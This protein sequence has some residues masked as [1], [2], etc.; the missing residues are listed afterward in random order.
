MMKSKLI[1][2]GILILVVVGTIFI[3]GY[4]QTPSG[5]TRTS[6]QPPTPTLQEPS[7]TRTLQQPPTQIDL[8]L[9]PFPTQTVEIS[10]KVPKATPDHADIVFTAA[11]FNNQ[12]WAR[13]TLQRDGDRATGTVQLPTN[14]FLCYTYRLKLSDEE[15][16]RWESIGPDS[17]DPFRVVK[18]HPNLTKIEDTVSGWKRLIRYDGPVNLLQG[19]V[20][21][22]DGE[23]IFYALV[24]AGG[25]KTYTG[26]DGTYSL[27]L[28]PGKHVVT[29][30][31]ELHDFKAL[32]RQVDLSA[33]KILDV[34]LEKAQKVTVTFTAETAEDL[35]EKIRI[36][37]NTYQL[38]TFMSQ[39]P[40]VY[41][42]R[43]LVVDR[44][45]GNKYT[46]TVELHDGQYL[47]YIYTCAGLY[48]GAEPVHDGSG[49]RVRRLLVTLETTQINDHLQGFRHNPKLTINLR[50]PPETHPKENILFGTI[51]MF[52]VGENQYQ[53]KLFVEPGHKFEYNYAHGI[54]GEGCEVIDPTPQERRHFTMGD[55]DQVINDVVEKWPFSD[56][57][58]RT[59]TINTDI[60]VAPRSEFAVGHN[61]LDWWASNFLTNFDGLTDDLVKEKHDYVGISMMTDYL[62]VEPEP[63]FQFWF[64]PMEDLKEA[65]RIAHT[66]GLKVIV[67][68]V[69][70]CD[71]EYQ[72]FFDEH[73][74]T[75]ISAD[76]YNA[77]FDQ[78]EHFFI[79]FAKVAEEA[80]IEVIQFPSPPP[81]VTDEY[82]D[83]IDQRMNQLITKT[84][85]VYS[86]KLYS[87]VHWETRM[88]Y[89]SN[90][91][92][93]DPGFSQVNLG[94]SSNA[95]VEEMKA[96]FDDLFD[97]HVKR[98]YDHYRV[99]IAMWFTYSTIEGAASGKGVTEPYLVVKKSQDYRIDL[100]EHERLA[101]AFMQ[102]VAE[103][104]YI[105]L[106]LGRDYSY[107]HLPS[108]PGPGF[109]SKPAA[110]V[111][112]EY[113]ELI[114]QAIQQQS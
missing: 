21:D 3:S 106:V 6:Q 74:N 14:T 5:P 54:P 109:R 19:T 31:T 47:E 12:P 105:E 111:W 30:F 87:P 56:Y 91:D 39:G 4:V 57:G 36:V 114:K 38:G 70:G 82:L 92:L 108:D 62:R 77:W 96:A 1:I 48:L 15:A 78:M 55:S 28:P 95:S 44:K 94:V 66:K 27:Y 10:L 65:V 71:Y 80:G 84:R 41:I 18:V 25:V 61:T 112:G 46:A 45:P 20:T 29:F 53:L 23:P 88:T 99:P 59:T 104:G 22:S 7:P 76:W 81:S 101:N 52:K 2:Y 67:F 73:V 58:E 90:L 35:P 69:I 63:R 13:I 93:L 64:T 85:K 16:E 103:R 60:N 9:Q 42:E 107:I 50:T 43:A 17:F 110:E 79:G 24:V 72:Q 86:G 37:G 8:T 34:Q 26:Y 75:G 100:G 97:T 33:D 113:N 32:S 11:S 51:P 49:T 83:L 102:S 98:I 40:M 68:Q 89:F